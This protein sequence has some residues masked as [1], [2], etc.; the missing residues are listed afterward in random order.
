LISFQPT[1]EQELIRTTARE[2]AA[3]A[4]RDSARD[5]DEQ[6][7]LPEG[8]LDASW[9]LGLT[10]AQIPEANGGAGMPRSPLL[11]AMALE[12]LAYGDPALAMAAM[13]P[14]LFAFSIVDHGT[15]DQKERFL[16]LFCGEKFHA[17]SLALIEP[18][19]LFDPLE[20][21]TTATLSGSE[22]TLRG[23]KAFVPLAD[24]ASHFLVLARVGE[25][26][27]GEDDIAAFI[28]ERDAA[29]LTIGD[30]GESLGLRAL[31]TASLE[32]DQ[33]RVP[34]ADRLGGDQG[35]DIRSILDAARIG[36]AA[37]QVGLSKAVLDY[38]TPYAK[39]RVAFGEAIGRKQAVA[40]MLSDMAIEIDSMRWMVWK[41]A[42]ELEKGE[43]ATRSAHLAFRYAAEQS[44][45][46][47]DNGLQV[48][49]GHGFIRE[50]P[51]EM[52]YR[53]ARTL[54]VLEG[55]ATV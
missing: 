20:L 18:G 27:G 26:Q 19:P 54:G 16:P 32:L 40:F 37:V 52:W 35:A 31:P 49:G 7:A 21:K 8:F 44:M 53:H 13:A 2:F 17:A 28:V 10:V 22:W 11:G 55:A 30:A 50:Y 1:E 46:I 36:T 39:E 14:A 23:K 6:A 47:A 29:G 45:K 51:V 15:S 43:S 3:A 5:A 41:A 4:M 42:S 33:V 38:A 25:G 9:A 48:F 34:A 24:A 12:E